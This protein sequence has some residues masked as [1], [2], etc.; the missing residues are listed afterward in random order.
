VAVLWWMRPRHDRAARG[1]GHVGIL[2]F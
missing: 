2:G 1:S